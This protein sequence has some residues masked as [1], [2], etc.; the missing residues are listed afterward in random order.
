LEQALLSITEPDDPNFLAVRSELAMNRYWHGDFDRVHGLASEVL[1][2]ARG[3]EDTLL[4]CLAASLCSLA[5]GYR[6]DVVG[7]LA[8]LREAQAAFAALADERLAERIYITHYI[9]EAAVRLERP[10][11]ALS[12]FQRGLDV[13]HMTGQDATSS[14]WSGIAAYALLLKGQVAE[15]TR[16]TEDDFDATALAADSFRMLILLLADSLTAFWQGRS[17]RVLQIAR[18]LVTRSE[19]SHPKTMFPELARLRLGAALF[20]AGDPASA[21]TELSTLDVEA[22]RWMLDLDSGHG[23]DMLIRSK[24]ALGDFET[25]EGL[26]AC[27]ESR[28]GELGQRTAALRSARAAVL[29]AA[30]DAAASVEAAA[31]AVHVAESADNPLLS[32]RCC[33]Q[34]GNSLA[35]TGRREDGVSELRRAERVLS[36][37]GAFREADAA[38][39]ELR[40]LGER[41]RRRS[42][43]DRGGG[44]TGLSS[45]EREVADEVAAGKTN[46]DIAATLFLSEKTIESHLARIY[47]KLDVHSRAALTA[48]V[49]RERAP[50]ESSDSSRKAPVP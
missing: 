22:R 15:A 37:C 8:E 4:V 49:A 13:A 5:S 3:R 1:S 20:A 25:A 28:D 48:I 35:A 19:R 45:R 30:G 38:A 33:I 43:P 17:E 32:G 39:H 14:S 18:D 31:E 23:W 50:S 16:I 6:C 12:H 9:S 46:R 40:R 44:L 29:L 47:S 41:V 34:Y 24:L 11:E 27:A 26:T 21:V 42:R 10:D 7:A 36:E 2:T